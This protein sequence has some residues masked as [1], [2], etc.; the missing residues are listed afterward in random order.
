MRKHSVKN[1]NKTITMT[2]GEFVQNFSK[3]IKVQYLNISINLSFS[4]AL[5]KYDKS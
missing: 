1:I 4:V 3:I 2:K 5:N